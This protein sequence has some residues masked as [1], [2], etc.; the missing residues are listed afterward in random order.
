MLTRRS[1]FAVVATIALVAAA[2]ALAQDKS[3]VVASTTSTQDSGLFGHILPVFKAKTGTDVK[4]VAQGTGQALDTGRRGDAD[5]LFVHAKAQE[6]KF[7]ADG[8][9]VPRD[10]QRFC[11]DRTEE[12]PCRHQGHDR[13]RRGFE[14]HQV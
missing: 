14:G 3:I 4:V 1:L 7:V 5:V 13:R 6:E 10:V 2:P 9:G 12:R 11:P 8:F